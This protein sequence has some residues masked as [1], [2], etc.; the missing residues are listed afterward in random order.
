MFAYFIAWIVGGPLTYA[1]SPHPSPTV[2]SFD[3]CFAFTLLCLFLHDGHKRKTHGKKPTYFCKQV[4]YLFFWLKACKGSCLAYH[5]LQKCGCMH[6]RFPRPPGTKVC[7]VLNK[8]EGKIFCYITTCSP[9]LM[10]F[11]QQIW[12]WCYFSWFLKD[13]YHLSFQTWKLIENVVQNGKP[14]ESGTS[15]QLK[16]ASL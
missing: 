2:F 13:L 6:Y 10:I 14:A 15:M 1:F 16:L 8:T 12:N 7:D 9:F 5:Q 11:F 3:L 4:M